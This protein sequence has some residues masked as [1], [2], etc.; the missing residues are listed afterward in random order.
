MNNTTKS[1]CIS[2]DLLISLISLFSLSS[3]SRDAL[4]HFIE[5]VEHNENLIPKVRISD[6]AHDPEDATVGHHVALPPPR[7]W[8]RLEPATPRDL[9]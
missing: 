8:I 4:P 3:L 2:P 5:P 9:D 7:G 1:L 6:L